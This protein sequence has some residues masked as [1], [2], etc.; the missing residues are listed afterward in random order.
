MKRK[1]YSLIIAVIGVML[2]TQSC[3]TRPTGNNEAT[4]ASQSEHIPD[5][6]QA[7]IPAVLQWSSDR[8][9]TAEE[10]F[11]ALGIQRQPSPN[12]WALEVGYQIQV[13]RFQNGDPAN[14]NINIP[15]VQ[16]Q[17]QNSS[18][19]G[20]PDYRHGGDI[21]G[22]INRLGYLQ[23][24][25]ITMLWVTPV[26]ANGNGSYH[27][28]CTSDFTKIDPG[29]GTNE[30][31]RTLVKKAHERGIKIVLDIVANHIC[32][33]GTH[34]ADS[35][36]NE[37]Y[38]ACVGSMNKKYW[39]GVTVPNGQRS[40]SFSSNFFPPFKSPYFLTRCGYRAGD[41]ASQGDVA[42]FGDFSDAMLDFDTL[43][44]DFQKIYTNLMRWWIAYAD[45]DGFRVDAAKH[46]TADFVARLSTESRA[47][48]DHLGKKNFLIVGEVAGESFEQALRV[49][50]MRSDIHNPF[51]GSTT[52]PVPLRYAMSD[53][54]A[55]YEQHA[56]WPRPGLNAV[57]DFEAS[58]TISEM[59]RRQKTSLQ[60]KQRFFQGSETENSSLSESYHE[61]AANGDTTLNWTVLEI[62]DWPRF[63]LWGASAR[64]QLAAAGT[65]LT[66]I[67]TPVIYYGFE[68][69]FNGSCPQGGQIKV[70]DASVRSEIDHTCASQDAFNHARYRQDMFAAG[71]WR[72]GST[73]SVINQASGIGAPLES[74]NDPY[75]STNHELFQGIKRFIGIRQSCHALQQ[76]AI[77]FRAAHNSPGLFAFSRIDGDQE[78]LV[79]GN[80][81][82]GSLP[83]SRIIVDANISG[84][85]GE[86]WR[87]LTAS[88]DFAT[89]ERDG[90]QAFVK[91]NDGWQ[92]PGESVAIFAKESQSESGRCK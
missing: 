39:D 80:T 64:Q 58:G 72:L 79:L 83:V 87:N 88:G 34:Y 54:R 16:Q 59:W 14:D 18:K 85:G 82:T 8:L 31:F 62:H 38:Q 17:Y 63:A 5:A 12:S 84:Q 50:N 70:S 68:Q 74:P 42:L 44:V 91:L 47:Y 25:G 22:I 11:S 73:I 92:I 67:G 7:G 32:D 37:G 13:D 49:G 41:F 90:P 20:L 89:T 26:F 75:V 52:T 55:T 60:F 78:I 36:S 15:E 81:S 23:E 33:T 10:S 4:L 29:F 61:I 24:L 66:S 2:Q 69:G 46:V 3:R 57:Y 35:M 53:L 28:Y 45:V 6:S 19:H 9:T 71:V 76:G 51:N 65:L 30:L 43:N 56:A 77:Y 1:H 48:A 27:G 21:Q 86:R 40:L